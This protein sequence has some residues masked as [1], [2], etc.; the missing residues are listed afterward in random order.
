M[1]SEGGFS[2]MAIISVSGNFCTDKK[3]AAINWIDGR[4][5]SVVAEAII[6]GEV[7]RSVLKSDVDALV[8]LVSC[9]AG[10]QRAIPNNTDSRA[11]HLQEPDRICHGRQHRWFQR[12]RGQHCRSNLPRDWSRSRTGGRVKQ[13]HN[14]DEEPERQPS[15]HGQHALYRGRH[16]RWRNRPRAPSSNAGPLG[17]PRSSPYH[18]WSQLPAVG[19]GHCS[20]CVG[21]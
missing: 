1:R 12:T 13:L 6:P 7:V 21:G 11:E 8:E 4:G 14:G 16:D 9:L 2:D 19:K 5:K 15:N 18:S 17:S 3:S 10:H 20:R